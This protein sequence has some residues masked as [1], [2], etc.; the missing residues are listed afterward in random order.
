MRLLA[1]FGILLLLSS[2]TFAQIVSTFN[3]NAEGWTTPNDADGTITYVAT[4]GNP[5]GFVSGSPFVFV[6]GAGTFYIPFNFVAPA[7]YLGN[8]SA[9][10][11]GT[12]RYDIQQSS[13]GAP[14]VYA[15]VTIANNLGILLYY[16]PTIP[17][18]PVAPPG[19]STF[20]VTLN[21]ALG[22]WKTTNSATGPVATEAQLLGVLSDL[23]ALEIRGLYRNA[24]TIN[25]LDNVSMRPPIVVTTQ[26]ASSTVCDGVTTTLTTAAT[27]NPSITYQWQRETSP[28]VWT[29]VTNTG[30]YSG[31]T[32]ATLTINTTGNFGAGNYR[33]R[34]SG[35]GVDDALTATAVVTINPLPSAPTTTG[36]TTCSASSFFLTAS[37]GTAGQYRWYTVPTGGTP[38]AG[39]TNFSYTTPVLSVTTTYYVAINNGTCESTRT[40][41]TATIATPPTAPSTTSGSSCATSSF[42]LSASGGTAGQ[43]R[44]YTVSTGG[45]ALAGETN[46]TYTTP[47]LTTT[48]TYYVAINNGICESS[49]TSVTA[50]INTPPMAPTTSGSSACGDASVTLSASG[51]TAGQYRWYTVST[52]GSAL[53]GETN[54]TY[55]TPVLSTTTTYYVA[56]NNGICESSRTSVTATINTPPM[57]PTTSGSSACGDASV[58]LSASGGTAGQYRWYTVST[59][60]TALA[61]QTNDTYTTP[62]LTSTTSY[63]VAIHD[64]TC[65]SARTIVTATINPIPVA[66]TTTGSSSCLPGSVTVSASGG[67]AGQ[68]RW[69]TTPTGGTALPGETNSTL[70]TPLL[71]TT[72]TYYVSIHDGTCESARS[73]VTATI[74]TP[75]CNNAP[76]AIQPV[77]V[78]TQIGGT[79][80]L[81]LVALI[82]D[83][84]NNLDLSTLTIVTPPS[85]GAQATIDASFNLVLDYAGI[86]FSGIETITI[87]VCDI[88][89]ACTNQVFSIEVIGEIEIYNA[90]SPNNDGKNDFFDIRYIDKLPETQNNKVTI[91]NRWGTK[92]F[93]VENY[94]ESKAFRGISSQGNE[95]PAGTYF[96]K[97]EFS[98]GRAGASG[99]LILKR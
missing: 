62:T 27:G 30:G 10:Y 98:G 65:E 6:G 59:G 42:T 87:R 34:I 80:T 21:N 40:A 47:V 69:Y 7:A 39:Q 54:A 82:S 95:L 35:I 44:W 81:N 26:P 43:Y 36:G 61:G 71:S 29:N 9:Y 2:H 33:C 41:V 22:F 17:N 55:T 76:P 63:Y 56:I 66:P 86:P 58:T 91:F 94:S 5:G 31:A 52:G 83:P 50:T 60:G 73:P 8:R 16:F 32:T 88:F 48:T 96:Y 85:S 97:I 51:G 72:T 93:E 49:R 64:G 28:S 79:I 1:V 77:P 68:Y 15:E 4:G 45:T 14:N 37:G 12:L 70:I 57:P 78:S 24:N 19:W 92:V 25:R 46:A 89:S 75:G 90:V 38:I 11:N 74:A 13:T 99:Y 23:A 67:T 18:Q 53:A 3:V 84:D 20:S